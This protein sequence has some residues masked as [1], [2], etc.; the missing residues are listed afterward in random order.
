MGDWEALFACVR[1]GEQTGTGYLVYSGLLHTVFDSSVCDFRGL[2]FIC[3]LRRDS[4]LQWQLKH[5]DG[6][7]KAG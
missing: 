5:K 1:T 2:M 4:F 7:N 3:V 6:T